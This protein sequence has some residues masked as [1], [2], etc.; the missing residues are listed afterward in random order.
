MLRQVPRPSAVRFCRFAR[1]GKILDEALADRVL[2]LLLRKAESHTGSSQGT[3]QAHL[4]REDHRVAPL[5]RRH[6]DAQPLRETGPLEV[7]V[8][9]CLEESR[10]LQGIYD[11]QKMSLLR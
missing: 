10:I 3:G 7:R 1:L 6:L 11:I 5:L 4:K 2:Q 9:C 8:P